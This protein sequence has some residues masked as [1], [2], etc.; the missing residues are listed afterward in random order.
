MQVNGKELKLDIFD[1]ETAERFETSVR[2]VADRMQDLK[3]QDLN[4]T[5]SIRVQCETVAECFDSIF[6]EGT[7]AHV[8]DGRVNLRLAL[9][10]FEE[11]IAGA[12]AQKEEI[13]QLAH[14]VAGTQNA[15]RK[16]TK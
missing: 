11:L 1:L 16:G 4:L 7:A 5:E 3:K 9:T 14:S 15:E 13:V 12:N 2:R 8:F 10:A 6:G